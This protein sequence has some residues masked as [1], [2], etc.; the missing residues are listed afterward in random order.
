MGSEKSRPEGTASTWKTYIDEHPPRSEAV[1]RGK[2]MPV[3][4]L[5]NQ[6]RLNRGD[7]EQTLDSYLGEVSNEE[8]DA[9]LAY[10][11]TKPFVIDEKLEEIDGPSY[12]GPFAAPGVPNSAK[13][14]EPWLKYID[15]HSPRGV[16]VIRDKG[17]SVWSVVG[18]YK[19]YQGDKER[20]LANYRGHLTDQELDA[21]IS[22]YWA[23]PYL[24]ERKLKEIST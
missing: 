22:Y 24:I 12:W 19:L 21:A 14:D 8:L 20:L 5:V 18:Y 4:S 10:Y 15:E 6:F 23:K 9:A 1:I 3:W 17:M 13:N 2:G 16:P 11:W 7:K